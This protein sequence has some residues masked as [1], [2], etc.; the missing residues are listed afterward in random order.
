MTEFSAVL[1]LQK[2]PL[3][4]V[5]TPPRPLAQNCTE[6]IK[7][8]SENYMIH[9]FAKQLFCE[10]FQKMPYLCGFAGFPVFP[11]SCKRPFAEALCNMPKK[12]RLSILPCNALLRVSAIESMPKH[13]KRLYGASRGL[14]APLDGMRGTSH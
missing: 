8:L 9:V 13:V 1:S 11:Q 14:L 6:T 5:K 7:K 4:F 2:P 10:H 3:A 12:K